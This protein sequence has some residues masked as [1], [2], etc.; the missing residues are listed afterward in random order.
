MTKVPDYIVSVVVP[1]YNEGAALPAFHKSLAKAL[2]QSVQESYEIIYCDDGSTDDT[3]QLVSTWHAADP[4][5]TLISFSRNFGKE[6]ALSAGIAAARGAA[7]L[8]LDGDG[9]HPV[10]L[11]PEFIKAWRGGAQVVIGLRTGSS[12]AGWLKRLG[13]KLFHTTF[14]RL[15]GQQLVRGATDFRL[16]DRPVRQAFLGLAET[17]RTTK[18]LIDWLGFRRQYLPFEAKDR[19]SGSPAY[20]LPKLM[21]LAAN[22]FASLTPK[23]LYLFGYLGVFITIGALLLGGSVFVEQLL[24]AD[25]WHW[26]FTGTAMLGI[27]ILFL[28]GIILMS[29]GILSLYISHI[30]SQSKHRPLYVIDYQKSAGVKPGTAADES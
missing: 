17:D 2:Q 18:G 23:P 12:G 24:L 10:E 28:V 19:A 30:H 14:N 5:V 21:G 1:V 29:Q 8:M 25:P 7:T 27:L 15:T 16:V 13:S 3:S 9:Q 6:S 11:I 20:S 4:R 22:S 26:K